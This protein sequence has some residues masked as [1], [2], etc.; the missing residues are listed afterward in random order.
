VLAN[1]GSHNFAML[2]VRMSEDILNQIVAVL[3]AGDVDQW[4]AWPVYPSFANSVQISIKE[5]STTN[6]ETF[7]DYFGSKLV[8]TVLGSISNDVVDGAAPICRQTMLT[9][10]LDAPIAE[11]AVRDNVNIRKDFFNTWALGSW[12]AFET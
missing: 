10:V 3:I 8:H 1:V 9:D 11:L 6:L 5:F 12:S 4:D 7:L 2:R